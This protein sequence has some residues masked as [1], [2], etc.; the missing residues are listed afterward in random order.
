MQHIARDVPG[1]ICACV[2]TMQCLVTFLSNFAT[3][4]RV[5]DAIAQAA[6]LAALKKKVAVE[7]ALMDRIL[8]RGARHA[9]RL[10]LA[11]NVDAVRVT[12]RSHLQGQF[13]TIAV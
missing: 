13:A 2:A 1:I 11:R 8:S 10:G 5:S 7:T 6:L 9:K 12:C 3:T 4:V